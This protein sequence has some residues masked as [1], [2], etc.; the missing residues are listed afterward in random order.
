[1]LES[2]DSKVVDVPLSMVEEPRSTLD[3]HDCGVCK[4]NLVGVEVDDDANR[5]VD[6]GNDSGGY[7]FS[8]MTRKLRNPF[9]MKKIVG[10]V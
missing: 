7:H 4:R 10:F 6:Q 9:L 8:I 5:A 3:S 1:M 2:H